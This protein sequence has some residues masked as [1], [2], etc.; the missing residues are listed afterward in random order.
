MLVNLSKNSWHSK[1]YNFVKGYYPT[2]EFKSLCPYF[3]TIVSFILLS[4]VILLWKV[5]GAIA[6]KPIKKTI[7]SSSDK[8]PNKFF[9]WYE[10]K[11]PNIDKWFGRIYF[12]F[13]GLMFLFLI[14]VGLI[15]LF[16]EKGAWMGLVYI[17]AWIG[18]TGIG[19]FTV[20]GI[21]NFF[22][23]DTW[24]IIKGMIYSVK[25]K[26]CPMIKWD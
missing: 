12:G 17:F 10:K 3:W 15:Q 22:E 2:Y 4:P 5:F 20:F 6:I 1:Y 24:G 8:G 9:K 26:V 16:K 25:N 11:G 13:L 23:T 14:V 7:N 21:V 18:A 19:I